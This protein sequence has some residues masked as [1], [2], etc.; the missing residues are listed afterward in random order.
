MRAR[1][2]IRS[3]P[4]HPMLVAFP[5][6]LWVASFVFDVLAAWRGDPSFAAA[7]FYALIG[8]C[9]G[10]A[11]AAVP[12]AVDLF[13]VVPPGSS[14]KKR[15]Y[16]HGALNVLALALFITVAALRGGASVMPTGVTFLISG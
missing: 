16:V 12:G 11:L 4:I 8:G 14:A 10:A 3:H 6:G 1:A 15:G 2:Q 13:S 9:I 5:I 7:G